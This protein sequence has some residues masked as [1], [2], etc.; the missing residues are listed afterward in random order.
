ME[1]SFFDLSLFKKELVQRMPAIIL[2]ILPL[3]MISIA[4]ACWKIGPTAGKDVVGR[5]A[6]WVFITVWTC[7]GVL[8]IWMISI[9]ALRVSSIGYLYG[10]VGCMLLVSILSVVWIYIYSHKYNEALTVQI[11]GAIVFVSVVFSN[12]C[13]SIPSD[14]NIRAAIL[15][16]SSLLT[17]WGLFATML[18]LCEANKPSP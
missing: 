2:S 16:P 7:I 5:P 8:F 6:P 17:F 4:G 3:I 10:L 15:I 9:A 11:L 13:V 18:N 12:I 1:P 14:N